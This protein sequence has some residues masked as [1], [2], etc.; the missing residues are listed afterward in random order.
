MNNLFVFGLNASLS[1]P[2]K[3]ACKMILTGLCIVDS[4]AGCRECLSLDAVVGAAAGRGGRGRG[5][6]VH[7]TVGGGGLKGWKTLQ[8]NMQN[9]VNVEYPTS[10]SFLAEW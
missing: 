3:Y 10:V 9:G 5:V 1:L 7:G 6:D 8:R 4:L 2:L